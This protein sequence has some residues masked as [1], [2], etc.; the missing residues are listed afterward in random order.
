[1]E[2][3]V[4]W[5]RFKRAMSARMEELNHTLAHAHALSNDCVIKTQLKF[6]LWRGWSSQ[7]PV[8]LSSVECYYLFPVFFLRNAAR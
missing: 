5:I 8:E 7:T 1:M 4:P 6:K 2:M 3:K